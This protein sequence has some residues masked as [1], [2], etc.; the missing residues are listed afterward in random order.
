MLLALAKLH[1]A[2]RRHTPVW[3]AAR[4]VEAMRRLRA[5]YAALQGESVGLVDTWLT[6]MAGESRP[7]RQP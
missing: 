7:L 4:D 3:N 2:S 5:T 6:E 1:E